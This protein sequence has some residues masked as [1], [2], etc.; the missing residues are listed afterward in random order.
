MKHKKRKRVT[1]LSQRVVK[2]LDSFFKAIK[3]KRR[4]DKGRIVPNSGFTQDVEIAPSRF[5]KWQPRERHTDST[6]NTYQKDHTEE[7]S[8]DVIKV[9][10]EFPDI[11]VLM[12]LSDELCDVYC[13][14]IHET[15]ENL[16]CTCERVDEIEF[17]G[18]ILGK[19]YESIQKA[20]I[21]IAE[22][23]TENPNVYY[24]LGYA[25]ALKKPVILITNDIDS[26]PFDVRGFNHIIYRNI[27]DL[28]AKL[29]KRLEN[30]LQNM[31]NWK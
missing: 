15:V 31:G 8:E 9:E 6:A 13:F 17:N 25:V 30:L 14:G 16:N 7:I 29:K 11:F 23:S 26:A 12:P 19:I 22:L 2:D 3:E 1:P 4:A 24:E 18:S 21:I 20:K 28:R 10:M 5:E 27:C